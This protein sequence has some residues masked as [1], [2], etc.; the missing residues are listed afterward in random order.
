MFASRTEAR[1]PD[2][3]CLLRAGFLEVAVIDKPDRYPI[4]LGIIGWVPSEALVRRGG[5][6][7]L[8]MNA[9]WADNGLGLRRRTLLVGRRETS[10]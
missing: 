8:G 10:V 9:F 1:G 4:R 7:V 5:K 2:I 6:L 3:D